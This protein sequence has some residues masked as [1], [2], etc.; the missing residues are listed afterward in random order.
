MDWARDP[1][2]KEHILRVHGSSCT[3][4]I[5]QAVAGFQEQDHLSVATYF[6]GKHP[7]NEDIRTRFISTIA[8]QLGLSFP[9]VREDIENLVA[10]DPTI[11]SRSVSSQLDTLILQPF[12][13]FLSV[14]DGV[15]IGQYNP[16]LIIVD[17]CDYLDMYTRTHIINALLGIAKQFPLRVRIL[18]FTK[19]SARIT[20]SL[21][22][23]VEDGSVMEI[24]F[25]DERSV[26]DIFTKIWNRIKRFTST[27]G[28]A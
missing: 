11:L 1:Q 14:P 18:L 13:P 17:G 26:G 27:N 7:N 12:A 2:A 6:V 15:V 20:T 21:S 23:G 3:S 25:D 5:A 10:H 8:Y 16:A 19:S 9:T 4:S 28:R 24:G 22:L